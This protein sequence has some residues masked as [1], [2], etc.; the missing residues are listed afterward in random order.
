MGKPQH[1]GTSADDLRQA[2]RDANAAMKDLQAAIREAREAK[3]DI[4]RLAD[5]YSDRVIAGVERAMVAHAATVN[6]AMGKV[7]DD[8]VRHIAAMI[9]KRS[10]EMRD[11]AK[12]QLK[13]IATERPQNYQTLKELLGE[14]LL[15]G[16]L[17]DTEDAPPHGVDIQINGRNIVQG[18]PV[19]TTGM[20]VSDG[21]D[22]PKPGVNDVTRKC[23]TCKRKCWVTPAR[24]KAVNNDADLMC[25]VCTSMLMK[26]VNES[27][28]T[29]TIVHNGKVI[30][31]GS[32]DK[33]LELARKLEGTS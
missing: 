33:V 10:A 25:V 8:A 18:I 32:L 28:G 5:S 12:S 6:E 16:D 3:E 27:G 9:E 22:W 14:P 31:N 4:M 13:T 17:G 15:E 1:V 2:A 19:D 23:T 24:L 20:R 21:G 29:Q 30:Y 26:L 11:Y 7:A